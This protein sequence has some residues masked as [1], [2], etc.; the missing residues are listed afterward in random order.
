[1]SDKT[2]QEQ[3][4]NELLNELSTIFDDHNIQEKQG[5]FFEH[6]LTENDKIRYAEVLERYVENFRHVAT[7]FYHT[8][9]VYLEQNGLPQFLEVS[10]KSLAPFFI[11]DQ[12]L[13]KSRFHEESGDFYSS[14]YYECWNLLTAFEFFNDQSQKVIL[15]QTGLVYLEHILESTAV[16]IEMLNLRPTSE[17]Q[18]YNAVKVVLKATFPT[19]SEP[20]TAFQQIA[21]CYKPDILL[22]S[23]NCAIEYK[24][25]QN[26]TV[27]INTIDQILIDVNGYSNN[28]DYKLF[29]AVF[30]VKAGIWNEARFRDVWKQKKFP[31]NWKGKMVLHSAPK[32]P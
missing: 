8:L 23:L 20:S 1:M 24:Y 13:M 26:E 32:T 15:K 18:V 16:I 11:S 10:K 29:Y 12:E 21:K 6:R 7:S 27:L 31:E 14:F 22:P 25:A 2:F 9:Q 19:A 28:P 30:Y 17:T 4:L 5:H 3:K